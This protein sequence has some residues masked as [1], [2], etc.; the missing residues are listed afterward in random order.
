MEIKSVVRKVVI[1][2]NDI[3]HI[4][5][6]VSFTKSISSAIDRGYIKTEKDVLKLIER[7]CEVQF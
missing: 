2:I 7:S 4:V 3:D 6:E 5:E 1:T